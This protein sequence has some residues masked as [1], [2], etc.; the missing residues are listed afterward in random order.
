MTE[1]SHTYEATPVQAAQLVEFATVPLTRLQH[2]E[3]LERI[4][5]QLVAAYRADDHNAQ[6]RGLAALNRIIE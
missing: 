2:L 1:Q 5:K 6:Q 3:M 4:D